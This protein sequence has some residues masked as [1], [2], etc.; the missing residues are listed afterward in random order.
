MRYVNPV[1][2]LY[3]DTTLNLLVLITGGI[4]TLPCGG[5]GTPW[6][7]LWGVLYLPMMLKCTLISKHIT[8]YHGYFFVHGTLTIIFKIIQI[9]F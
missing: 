3:G 2:P 6:G 7:F 5:S 4:G 1:I 8:V 9:T